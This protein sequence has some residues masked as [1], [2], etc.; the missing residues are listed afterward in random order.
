MSIKLKPLS[1]GQRL[2]WYLTSLGAAAWLVAVA[3]GNSIVAEALR[4]LKPGVIAIFAVLWFVQV[5]ALRIYIQQVDPT[6]LRSIFGLRRR[7]K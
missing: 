3:I 5:I 7:R 4:E 6:D 2:G 1:L